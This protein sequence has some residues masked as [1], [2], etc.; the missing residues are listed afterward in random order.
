MP[1]QIQ[2][3]IDHHIMDVAESFTAEETYQDVEYELNGPHLIMAYSETLR[4]VEQGALFTFN[5]GNAP[6]IILNIEKIGDELLLQISRLTPE[7]VVLKYKGAIFTDLEN[8][9]VRNVLGLHSGELAEW[10]PKPQPITPEDVEVDEEEQQ[11]FE[12]KLTST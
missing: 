1:Q 5:C 9:Y 2:S 12:E 10:F 8:N 7:K 11:E 3:R 6:E 4:G